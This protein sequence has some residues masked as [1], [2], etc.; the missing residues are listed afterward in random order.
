MN[1]AATRPA[2]YTPTMRLLLQRMARAGHP[3]LYM[4]P[5]PVARMAHE[6]TAGILEIAPPAM[7]RVEDL[8]I[9]TRNGG[10]IGARFYAPVAGAR[11]P[12]L[13][14]FH[15]GGFCIGSVNTHDVICRALARVSGAAVLSVN[16][17]LAPE[18]RF[19]AA[20][21][22]AWDALDW[23]MERG[24]QRLEVDAR[25][26]AIGGDSAGGTLATVGAIHARDLGLGLA[27]QVLIYPGTTAHQDTPSHR[28]YADNPVLDKTQIDWFFNNYIDDGE[29][30]DWRFAPLLADD[31]EGVAPAWIGLAEC[32]PLVDEGV[33]YGDKLRAAGVPV[34]LEIYRGVV[35]GFAQMSRALPEARQLFQ[36]VGRALKQ[37]FERPASNGGRE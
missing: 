24:P 8:D 13:L 31:V 20:V 34:E 26:V 1:D 15:G 12:V 35:H 21:N 29:R 18:F 19:P 36:E 10:E 32:D 5:A 25:R 30:T 7:A 4:L 28:T 16:Y 6:K 22:D 17:R 14:Y 27:L 33:L 2:E 11:L 37:A 3:P 23:L 9:P